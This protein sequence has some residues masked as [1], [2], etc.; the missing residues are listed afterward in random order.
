[1]T[2]PIRRS[3]ASVPPT[4]WEQFSLSEGLRVWCGQGDEAGVHGLG[5]TGFRLKSVGLGDICEE[6]RLLLMYIDAVY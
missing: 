2:S 1:M 4:D 3:L 6:K 5:F